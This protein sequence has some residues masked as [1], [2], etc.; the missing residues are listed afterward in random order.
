VKLSEKQQIFAELASRLMQYMTSEGYGYTFG[1]AYRDPRVHGAY[2]EKKSYS[3]SRSTHKLRL[4]ID[5]NLFKD[6]VYLTSTEAHRHFGAWWKA[7]HPLARWGGDFDGG[8]GNH[9]SFEH[10]GVA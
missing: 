6:G 10:D 5:L 7:Q 3:H 4:A 2:G 8:D 1:D 9:Y